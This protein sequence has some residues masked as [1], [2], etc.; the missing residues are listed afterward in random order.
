LTAL[1]TEHA[2]DVTIFKE[3]RAL[4]WNLVESSLPAHIQRLAVNV[5]Y[6][7]RSKEEADKDRVARQIEIDDW[8]ERVFDNSD[9]WFVP[10]PE[11][12]NLIPEQL[13]RT[14]FQHGFLDAVDLWTRQGSGIG[15]LEKESF[16]F[17]SYNMLPVPLSMVLDS[18]HG[19]GGNH[20]METVRNWERSMVTYK[21][22]LG[23]L[24]EDD[25]LDDAID[26]FSIPDHPLDAIT[27]TLSHLILSE[28]DVKT[29]RFRFQLDRSVKNLMV[30]VGTRYAL[31]EKQFWTVAVLLKRVMDTPS[32]EGVGFQISVSD[33]FI[34]YVGGVGG[35]GKTVLI[36]DS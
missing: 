25:E 13:S 32:G 4:I 6:L 34:S 26:P 27:P 12:A 18:T 23:T 3:P 1:F 36:S 29:L 19:A 22:G 11:E 31:N 5:G 15:S 30:L 21:K 17:T 28:D 20:A 9:D 8:E 10:R 35:T 7:R 16:D 14:D 33:Q 2:S 24:Q